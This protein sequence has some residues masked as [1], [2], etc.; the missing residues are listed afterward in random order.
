MTTGFLW[1]VRTDN[2][3]KKDMWGDDTRFGYVPFPYPDDVAKEDTRIGVSGLSVYLYVSGRPYPAGVTSK[4]VYRAMNEMFLNTIK[5][6]EADDNF[7]PYSIKY[8]SLK[9]RIDNPASIEAIMFYDSSKVFYD[10]AHSIYDSIAAT[11]LKSP[12]VYVMYQGKDYDESFDAV[13]ESYESLF[14]Q[15]YS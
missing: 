5:Y 12:C 13:A 10:P 2:R 14:K 3:W 6:Q 8:N 15:I 1:F 4:D 11:V 9:S 7:D